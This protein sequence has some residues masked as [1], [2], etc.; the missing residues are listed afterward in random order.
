MQS[1]LERVPYGTCWFG[2]FLEVEA[3]EDR[4]LIQHISDLARRC[5]H[6]IL[7]IPLD[8]YQQLFRWTRLYQK[9]FRW[10]QSIVVCGPRLEF[11]MVLEPLDPD[12]HRTCHVAEVSLS[13]SL[14]LSLGCI[15]HA[16]WRRC[17]WGLEPFLILIFVD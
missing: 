11:G 6:F 9:F 1:L 5:S 12:A 4:L 3:M 10:T 17:V 16:T 15:G 14:S 7:E 8:L 2:L 13:L